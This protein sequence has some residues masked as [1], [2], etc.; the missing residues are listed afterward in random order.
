MSREGI[1]N[2]RPA[3]Q[4]SGLQDKLCTL[5]LHEQQIFCS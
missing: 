5:D 3:W 2:Y 4:Q 1:E